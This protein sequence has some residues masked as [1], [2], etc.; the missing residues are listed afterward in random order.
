MVVA[1]FIW[2]YE[3][4]VH[5]SIVGMLQ[6]D[7]FMG[8][9]NRMEMVQMNGIPPIQLNLFK[10]IPSTLIS[11]TPLSLHML[12]FFPDW[13]KQIIMSRH[14]GKTRVH[15]QSIDTLKWVEITVV[16]VRVVLREKVG[17]LD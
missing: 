1:L 6:Y 17:A 15:R 12:M 14:M 11:L 10:H 5:A 13:E 9:K 3:V 4:L 7:L 8:F 2:P 16:I